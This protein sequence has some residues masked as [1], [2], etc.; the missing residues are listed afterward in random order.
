MT[1]E[2]LLKNINLFDIRNAQVA[3]G[4]LSRRSTKALKESIDKLDKS[5]GLYSRAISVLTVFLVIIAI[6]QLFITIYPPKGILILVYTLPDVVLLV[7]AVWLANK[8]L[9]IK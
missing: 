1:E 6:E 2:E 4:E 3:M 5:T 7:L 9:G 8:V